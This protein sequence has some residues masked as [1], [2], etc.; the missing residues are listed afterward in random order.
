MNTTVSSIGVLDKAVAVLEAVA[1]ADRPLGLMVGYKDDAERNDEV[2]RDGVCH[3]GDVGSRDADGYSTYVGR[4][5]EV[6]PLSC[7][8]GQ[9]LRFQD[10]ATLVALKTSP[11]LAGIILDCLARVP[12]PD[13]RRSGRSPCD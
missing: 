3:T 6:Q 9:E 10:S 13:E 12:I 7:Y 5:D 2:M 8:E 1:S 11:D 4:Y